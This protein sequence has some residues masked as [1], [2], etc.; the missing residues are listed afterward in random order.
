MDVDVDDSSPIP[1]PAKK[2]KKHKKK[3]KHKKDI[4]ASSHESNSTL[5]SPKTSIKLKLKIGKET[6]G[7]KNVMSIVKSNETNEGTKE[8]KSSK[9]NVNNSDDDISDEEKWLDALEKGN[10]DSY[11]ELA[12]K[13]PSLLTARQKALL[14]GSQQDELLQ[15]PSGY[16]TVEL[17]DEQKKKR[18]EKAK[19]RR[20]QANEKMENDK[21][22]TVHKL[23]KKQ[24]SKNKRAGKP[25][26]GKRSTAPRIV[27]RNRLDGIYIHLP[28]DVPFPLTPQQAPPYPEPKLCGVNGCTNLRTSICS[29][30][31]IPVCSLECYK[32]NLENWK[33]HP[34][35]EDK[36][37]VVQ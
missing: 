26:G 13:D 33:T 14:H 23:L 3:H 9:K 25:R 35:V 5:M 2:H 28:P 30:T 1:P 37:D 32:L 11:S 27:Y 36:P 18:Q 4:E 16:K 24:D 22:Q 31:N 34:V 29:K 20:Q 6:M 7:T 8:V 10:L 21:N 12:K 15:L 17:T 19:R